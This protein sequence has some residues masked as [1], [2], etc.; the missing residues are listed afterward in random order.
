MTLT[1]ALPQKAT[2]LAGGVPHLFEI[3]DCGAP[4]RP[5]ERHPLTGADD[6]VFCRGQGV[7]RDGPRLRIGI[8]DRFISESHARLRREGREWR[9]IDAGSTNGTFVNGEPVLDRELADGDVLEMGAT[10]FLFRASAAVDQESPPHPTLLTFSP[11][12]AAEL[13][14]VPAIARSSLPAII[15]GPTGTGKELLARA[16]HELSGRQGAFLAVNCAA[17]APTLLESELFGYRKGAFS[18][19]VESR[20]GLVRAAHGGTLLLDEIADLSLPAQAALLRVLQEREV[21]PVGATEPV[22]IDVRVLAATHV[23]LE[24]AVAAQRF[25]ADLHARLAGFTL[26]LPPLQRRREDLGLLVAAILRRHLGVEATFTAEAGRAL[27]R[28]RWPGN[29]RE[30]E[31]CVA[32]ALALA[33]GGLIELAHLPESVR[34]PPGAH[35]T[36]IP[37]VRPRPLSAEDLRR[38]EQIAALLRASH[39]NVAAVARSLG[40]ARMQVHRWVKRFDLSL[41]DYR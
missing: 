21:L 27:L 4:C 17:I 40:K 8:P 18:G 9:A 2:R 3:F 28:H 37:G 24:D 32:S 38:R 6:V 30:L 7:S 31:Q 26:R 1:P 23:D 35:A 5:L 19:A 20:P 13:A 25:R 22:P 15:A 10:H 39:G 16:L 11:G 14:P 36:A 41:A 29:V 33:G 34:R 12:L